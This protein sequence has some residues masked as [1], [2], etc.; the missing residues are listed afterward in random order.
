MKK[1]VIEDYIECNG[2]NFI[3]VTIIFTTKITIILLNVKKNM[4]DVLI[5]EHI[6]FNHLNLSNHFSFDESIEPITHIIDDLNLSNDFSFDISIEPITYIMI[7]K[8]YI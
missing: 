5:D 3:V 7:R 1:K 8:K 2:T 6:T 4:G